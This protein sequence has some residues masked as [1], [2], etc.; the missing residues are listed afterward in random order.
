MKKHLGFGLLLAASLAYSQDPAHHDGVNRR[1]D[2]AMGFS[3]ETTAHHF[4]L[5]KDGGAIEVETKDSDDTSGRDA[6]R[7]H[8]THIAKL[9]TAGDFDVPMFIHDQVP[10]GVPVMKRLKKQIRYQFENTE[11]GARVRISSENAEAVKAVH[12]FLKFQIT[13]HQ[14]GDPLVP[15]L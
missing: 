5:L 8:L 13:D 7:Q 15:S 2:H 4:R 3:H 12:E 1:G 14:T 10:P 11:R 6:I 9:F